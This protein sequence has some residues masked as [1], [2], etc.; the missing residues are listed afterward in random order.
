[1]K[2]FGEEVKVNKLERSLPEFKTSLVFLQLKNAR[3]AWPPVD[4]E[5]VPFSGPHLLK[6]PITILTIP[7]HSETFYQIPSCDNFS[8]GRSHLATTRFML[9]KPT[10]N[11]SSPLEEAP[12]CGCSSSPF[13]DCHQVF[14]LLG[15]NV[16]TTFSMRW[17]FVC[18]FSSS[19]G[20]EESHAKH[21][22]SSWLMRGGE[23]GSEGLMPRGIPNILLCSRTQEVTF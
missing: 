6:P 22:F 19:Y 1:M 11:W 12:R 17:P 3:L 15:A 7:G 13:S 18:S 21:F 20:S 10:M 2:P 16:V 14:S 4:T 23:E 5:G 8:G 9:I